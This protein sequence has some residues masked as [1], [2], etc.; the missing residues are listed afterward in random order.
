MYLKFG[1]GTMGEEARIGEARDSIRI[2]E[3]IFVKI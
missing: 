1:L 2:N 3:M